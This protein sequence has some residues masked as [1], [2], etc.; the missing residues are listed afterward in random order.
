MKHTLQT[1]SLG[2]GNGSTAVFLD[3]SSY[4]RQ[5]CLGGSFPV[6]LPP[7]PHLGKR[8]LKGR[9]RLYGP[10]AVLRH[11]CCVLSSSPQHGGFESE[12][13][14]S[15]SSPLAFLSSVWQNEA[16]TRFYRLP[17]QEAALAR[18]SNLETEASWEAGRKEGT[19][20]RPPTARPRL[21]QAGGCERNARSLT[22]TLGGPTPTRF[23][24]RRP[25]AQ[26]PHSRS[27]Q[28]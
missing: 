9:A 13:H 8:R 11:L 24:T 1:D 25:W 22:R 4:L 26:A 20:S 21:P 5:C 27:P 15:A 3:V 19:S 17:P 18:T 12:I 16:G 6:T 14:I 7:P 28:S 23:F 2:F 10:R